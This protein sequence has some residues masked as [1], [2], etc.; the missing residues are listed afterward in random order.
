MFTKEKNVVFLVLAVICFALIAA[1]AGC[2]WV[3]RQEDFTPEPFTGSAETATPG[4]PDTQPTEAPTGSGDSGQSTPSPEPTEE[5][6]PTPKPPALSQVRIYEGKKQAVTDPTE[7]QLRIISVYRQLYP[8]YAERQ[9]LQHIY[10]PEYEGEI[11]FVP[12]EWYYEGYPTISGKH[13]FEQIGDRW[14]CVYVQKYLEDH[15][16][17][18]FGVFDSD[19]VLQTDVISWPYSS[20]GDWPACL[21]EK[22]GSYYLAVEFSYYH[23]GMGGTTTVIYALPSLQEVWRDSEF[24]VNDPDKNYDQYRFE[25][26]GE[27]FNVYEIERVGGVLSPHV[28][29]KM[30]IS[31]VLD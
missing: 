15:R 10:N 28:I 8:E 17:F 27:W 4:T 20:A 2:D 19:F 24:L 18:R 23:S 12:D 13:V 9:P 3:R 25:I 16:E 14:L 11:F 31:S 30:K 6:D 26:E 21:F 22:D 1:T 7:E 5:P 29:A